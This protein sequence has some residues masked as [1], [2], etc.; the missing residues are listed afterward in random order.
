MLTF[1]VFSSVSPSG[2]GDF[3]TRYTGHQWIFASF[4]TMEMTVSE[5][6]LKVVNIIRDVLV[7]LATDGDIGEDI[8]EMN[9]HFGRVAEFII[10]Q[11]GLEII[12]GQD[13][14]VLA[15]LSPNSGWA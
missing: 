4:L 11:L 10:E 9:D 7:D 6:Q 2:Q 8:E 15:K 5:A 12:D 13:E 14:G 1:F 3:T